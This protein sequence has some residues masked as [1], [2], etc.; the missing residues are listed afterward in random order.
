MV[1]V[2]YMKARFNVL[3][4]FNY[5]RYKV[6]STGQGTVSVG[7]IGQQRHLLE[8][9]DT[10]DTALNGTEYAGFQVESGGNTEFGTVCFDVLS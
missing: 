3:F 7:K 8:W 5:S 1:Y 2:L 9:T 6:G 4:V 10:S